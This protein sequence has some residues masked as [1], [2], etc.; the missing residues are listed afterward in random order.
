MVQK[1]REI[2]LTRY[3][4]SILIALL[5]WQ[6][7]VVLIENVVRTLFWIID[8]QRSHSVLGSSHQPFPWDSLISSAVTI[9][10]YLLI[11]YSLAR[12]LYPAA[13]VDEGNG[14]P[15]MDQAELP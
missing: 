6:P 11:A 5:C 3:I 13:A 2:L 10:L 14:R 15:S 9:V 7:V 12:W 1:L 4:G 8:D